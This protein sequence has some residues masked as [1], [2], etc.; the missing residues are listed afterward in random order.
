MSEQARTLKIHHSLMRPILLMGAERDLV[1]ITAI[2]AAVLVLSLQR[3]LFIAA[4]VVIWSL[5]LGALQRAAKADP[6]LSRVYLRHV[7]YRAFYEAQSRVS[8]M[9]PTIREQASC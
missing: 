8:A 7:R 5:G 1:L 2:I 4:G 9:T 6:Q 3:P